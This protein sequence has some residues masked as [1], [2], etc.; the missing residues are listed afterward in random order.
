MQLPTKWGPVDT[1]ADFMVH[2]RTTHITAL[3]V[4]LTDFT[5]LGCIRHSSNN[6]WKFDIVVP[7]SHHCLVQ[8]CPLSQKPQH[9][10]N[11]PTDATF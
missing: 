6:I 9:F 10:R 8:F 5:I 3:E 7:S 2:V 11:C 1:A 4:Q